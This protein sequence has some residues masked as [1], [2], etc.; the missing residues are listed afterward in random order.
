MRVCVCTWTCVSVH[1]PYFACPV[2]T[3]CSAPCPRRARCAIQYA[4]DCTNCTPSPPPPPPP[5]LLLLRPVWCC[6]GDSEEK[7]LKEGGGRSVGGWSVGGGS[8]GGETLEGYSDEG[9]EFN[10]DGS[11]IGEYSGLE[12]GR[13]SSE[14]TLGPA[15]APA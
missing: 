6:R 9:L 5:P 1:V 11:F 4:P 12:R 13:A 7:P 8:V 15:L 2:C 14:G 10:E 3:L